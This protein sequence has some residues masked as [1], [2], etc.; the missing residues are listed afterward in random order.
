MQANYN[1]KTF[2]AIMHVTRIEEWFVEATSAE[3]AKLLL[4]SGQGERAHMGECVEI[5]FGELRD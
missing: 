1:R 3:E 5:E 2:H 4:Q